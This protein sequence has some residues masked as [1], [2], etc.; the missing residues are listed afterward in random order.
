MPS[1]EGRASEGACALTAVIADSPFVEEVAAMLE[2]D[3]ANAT[4]MPA[5][6][7][8]QKPFWFRLAAKTAALTAPV[9]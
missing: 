3:M 7:L 2:A 8:E 9:Q 4:P 1:R 6:A 5:D